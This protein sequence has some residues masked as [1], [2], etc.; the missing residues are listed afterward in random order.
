MNYHNTIN[1]MSSPDGLSSVPFNWGGG[2]GGNSARR[3]GGALLIGFTLLLGWSIE[4]SAQRVRLPSPSGVG[5]NPTFPVIAVYYPINQ[6]ITP[7]TL[8]AGSGG[9]AP[10]TY[11]IIDSDEDPGAYEP[12]GL[13]FDP[14]TRVLSG[15][16]TMTTSTSGLESSYAATD[17]RIG[18]PQAFANITMF[19]V[20]CGAGKEGNISGL[21]PCFVDLAVSTLSDVNY[22]AGQAITPL[23]LPEATGG[24][25]PI[26]IN[27]TTQRTYT[28]APLPT[29]LTFDPD[30]RV[31]SG[32]PTTAGN[33]T[34]V[35]GVTDTVTGNTLTPAPSFTVAVGA[36]LGVSAPG[37]QTYPRNAAITALTLPEAVGG[38]GPYTYALTGP[39][40]GNLP[41]GLVFATGTRILSGTPTTAGATVLTYTATD[42]NGN[43]D[44]A[45]FTV[46]IT[47]TMF[48]EMVANQTYTI[49]RA[50]NL[51]LP[52][53]VGGTG[54][55][56]Y[57]LTGPSGG[58]L[59]VGLAF[60][61]GTRILSG[62][63][64]TLGDTVLTYTA[65]DA[66][67]NSDT[68]TFTV[69]VAEPFVNLAVSTLSD[70]NY[71]V[72]QPITSL[73][74]PEAT[75]GTGTDPLLTYTLIPLPT[76]LTFTATTRV[77]SGTPT[78]AGITTAVYGVTDTA[79]GRT[80]TPAAS[81]TVTVVEPESTLN[82]VEIRAINEV[83]VSEL[84]TTMT[85]QTSSA[86][87]QRIAQTRSGSG[88]GVTL[89]GQS[90]FADLATT[91]GKAMT[92]GTH[93]MKTMLNGSGFALPLNAVGGGIGVY[94]PAFWGS[95]GYEEISGESDL[96]DGK[97]DWDGD[98]SSFSVGVDAHLRNDLLGGIA[99]TRNEADLEYDVTN[100]VDKS[101]YELTMTSINPYL[102]WRVG[103]LDLWGTVGYGSGDLEI[104]DNG[105][106]DSTDIDSD[107]D[108]RSFAG[109][110]GGQIMALGNG[111]VLRL[112]GEV[113]QTWIDVDGDRATNIRSLDVDVN[114]V[115]VSLEARQPWAISHATKL[116]S[117]LEVG[118]RHDGGDGETGTGIE[119]NAGLRYHTQRLT[120]EGNI[121]TLLGRED[122]DEWGIS[123]TIILQS[124]KDGQGL[125]LSLSPG[126]GEAGDGKLWDNG[127]P[128]DSIAETDYGMRLNTRIGYGISAPHGWDGMLTPYS[129]MTLGNT[130]SYRFGIGWETN[131]YGLD[132]VGEHR[133]G[134]ENAALVKGEIRF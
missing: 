53:A 73:T 112:K 31:L 82:T 98:V 108:M 28:L 129:E 88:G 20:I 46:T 124:G 126:Y 90:S 18:T 58:N 59:P 17:G 117:T 66:N 70:V 10:L 92:E 81:F 30:T 47:T 97:L 55:Y 44:P 76:G 107:V 105:T 100:D 103:Q 114:R 68:M 34:P 106:M 131:H 35:Y 33:T 9:T 118:A 42:A 57:T 101:D 77:L 80:L 25:G 125:S 113:S 8:P 43:S 130:N 4:A 23:T 132:L 32:T 38:T 123:G 51:T 39:S 61:A 64:T 121:H 95:G 87:T 19:V 120:L 111:G 56:T 21:V 63:P 91:H 110:G 127:L 119:L 79:S 49:D 133:Q 45:T 115:R 89:A 71:V 94:S 16:P 13:T 104:T 65:T 41:A 96:T 78:T 60:A 128:E 12:L 37:V 52:G 72:N 15:T 83:F 14:A 69:T 74:L 29:G 134:G 27:V 62:T 75:G 116:Q 99:I 67:S 50:V 2:G 36:A 26:N 122:Y 54:S 5:A 1:N 85:G 40:G 24:T 93:D 3:F 6:T 48:T 7:L 11:S 109:G 86:I 22:V 84:A 102:G